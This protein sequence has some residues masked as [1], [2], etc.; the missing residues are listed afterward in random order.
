MVSRLGGAIS[1]HSLEIAGVGTV[2]ALRRHM[3]ARCSASSGARRRS[4]S[5][6]HTRWHLGN[7]CH[8]WREI[9]SMDSLRGSLNCW[10]WCGFSSGGNRSHLWV[11]ASQKPSSAPVVQIAR[12]IARKIPGTLDVKDSR[13]ASWKNSGHIGKPGAQWSHGPGWITCRCELT[14]W[15]SLLIMLKVLGNGY[16][17]QY[18]IP[19]NNIHVI[20]ASLLQIKSMVYWNLQ[21]T[22]LLVAVLKNTMKNILFFLDRTQGYLYT[23]SHK[24]G[25]KLVEAPKWAS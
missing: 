13:C 23:M 9:N 25:F 21:T 19:K 14:C 18:F 22:D 11:Y 10:W 7:W 4:S 1:W 20:T 3:R 6:G 16:F 15:T 17:I 12:T 5:T 2:A 24:Y 8:L